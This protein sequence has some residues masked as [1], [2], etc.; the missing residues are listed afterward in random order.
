MWVHKGYVRAGYGWSFP[1]GD[2]VR[3]GVG[4]FDPRDHVKEFGRRQD[5]GLGMCGFT[6]AIGVMAGAAGI[7]GSARV[8]QRLGEGGDTGPRQW[9]DYAGGP[10][11][12]RF[13][14]ARQIDRT[15]VGKLD[16]A[17]SYPAGDTD[18]NPVVVRGVVYGRAQGRGKADALVALDAAT[19]KELW[20]HDGI[21][22]FALRG[23]NY[24]ENADGSERR[25]FYSARNI[26][27]AIDAKTGKPIPSFGVNGVVDLREGLDRD[28]KAVDQQSRIPGR[29]FE[30][31]II[32]GSATNQEYKSAPG[33]I[34]AFDV[35]TGKLVWTFHTI[36]RKGEF[37]ADTWPE[38]ARATV[39][40]ANDWA[41][42]SVDPARGIVYVPTAQRQIQLLW[43]LSSWRQPVRQLHHRARRAHGQAPVALPDGSSRHL[44]RR[45]QLRAAV[46]DDSA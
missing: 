22:G 5:D 15:N 11:S 24:W 27:R 35:R 38:N 33:D 46:D 3:I 44:G 29:V 31:L 16:V 41:E 12:S 20:V 6:A 21:E 8:R 9:T 23:V 4:S 19:G 37:G 30:N 42:L 14:A 32:L 40:G 39:G 17:W 1:A 10:D 43:R 36:P 7:S 2:E 18:F 26:L 13:V 45:Q 34:R 28:P 25:L